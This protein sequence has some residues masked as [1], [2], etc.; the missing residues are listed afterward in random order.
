MG[1]RTFRP[2]SPTSSHV[3][4][5]CVIACGLFVAQAVLASDGEED[6]RNRGPYPNGSR[7]ESVKNRTPDPVGERPELGDHMDQARINSGDARFD[8]VFK[9]GAHLFQAR[10]NKL[11][12]QGRPT[13]TSAAPRAFVGENYIRTS[14]PDSSS[15]W[16]CHNLPRSGG[17]GDFNALMFS[18]LHAKDPPE[19]STVTLLTNHRAGPSVFGDGPLEMLAREMTFDLQAI[20]SAAKAEA[21]LAGSPVTKPL[22]TKGVSFGSITA[23]PDGKIN[24]SAI[25]GCDWDLVIK[26]HTHKGTGASLRGFSIGG[27][28]LH[29][30]MQAV[31][32]FGTGD[33]DGDGVAGELSIGD[34]TAMTVWMAALPVPGRVLPRDKGRQAAIHRGEEVFAQVQCASCHTPAMYLDNPNFSEPSPFNGTGMLTPSMVPQPFTF[35]LTRDGPGPRPERTRDGRAIIRAFTDLKRHNITDP[36]G[37][38]SDEQIPGGALRGTAPA[39]DFTIAA[40]SLAVNVFLTEK[41][42]DVG[43][44]GPWGHRGDQSSLNDAIQAHGGEASASRTAFNLLPQSDRDCVIEFLRSMQVVPVDAQR[45]TDRGDDVR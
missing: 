9:H 1:L 37:R 39:S 35:D 38:Q 26:P 32:R 8:E 43:S 24:P 12:G 19:M 33:A 4:G 34:V 7:F 23:L 41:L 21:A 36:S 18:S 44:T 10:F 25:V 13:F 31:E 42:W 40:P 45:I 27:S 15:C 30:G 29:L 22:T 11:D 6:G 20:R 2:F 5:A 14:G 16:Q 3:V 28:N 17:G